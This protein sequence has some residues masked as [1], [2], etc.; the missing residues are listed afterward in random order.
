MSK[1][2]AFF[3]IPEKE[4][5]YIRKNLSQ[6]NS[7]L[8]FREEL[9]DEHL[10]QVEDVEIISIFIYSKLSKQVI[11][12]LLNLKMVATRSTGFD[13][14]DLVTCRERN[15]A[16]ANVPN[17]GENTVAEHTLGLILALSRN[18][19]RGYL[20][21]IQRKFSFEGLMGFD[22]KGKI[23]G[24]IGAGHIGLRVIRMANGFGMKILV[25][26]VRR[27]NFLAEVLDF[28]YVSLD[29]LMEK[30]DIISLH[31]PYSAH[32]HHLINKENLPKVKRGAILIN[33]GRGA[34]VDTD[35]LVWALDEGI[36][37][38]AG[39]DVLEG[40]EL[41][42][43]ERQ[44]LSKNYPVEK[45]KMLL[46]NHILMNRENVVITPHIA[47]NSREALERILDTTI[48]NIQGYLER[49]AINLVG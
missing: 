29:E 4:E 45:L 35:A 17:Y 32:T 44:V 15:I 14:I 25:Y 37:G 46:Q 7:L 47:F 13:H 24:I 22:L 10:S 12:K 1:K 21:T 48:A 43:E 40:E 28:K 31:A 30:S 39:L 34:L 33:T 42:N 11:E 26:D 27:D 38:G 41:I 23:L 3:E 18:I 36:L 49:Q 8:F 5:L 9:S 6:K 20:R 2:I 19:H 16:V